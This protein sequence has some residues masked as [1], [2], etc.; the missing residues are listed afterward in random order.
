MGLKPSGDYFG[1]N[2]KSLCKGKNK[3]NL[4]SVDD[5]FGGAKNSKELKPKIRNFSETCR[6]HKITLNPDKFKIGRHVEFGGFE[7]ECDIDESGE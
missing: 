4:K 1:M 7:L 3:G 6:E 5:T 2:T